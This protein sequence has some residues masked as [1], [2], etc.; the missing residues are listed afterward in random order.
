MNMKR[1]RFNYIEHLCIITLKKRVDRATNN[2]L[3]QVH[4]NRFQLKEL[5][6]VVPVV[7]RFL[8]SRK[9]EDK[10]A[11]TA[12]SAFSG[13]LSTA[14]RTKSSPTLFQKKFPSED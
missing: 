4:R 10:T 12:S 13:R 2:L 11:Q 6:Q 3:F 5:I 9:V 1:R 8:T 14:A 7:T